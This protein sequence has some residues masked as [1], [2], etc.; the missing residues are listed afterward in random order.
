MGLGIAIAQIEALMPDAINLL[1]NP[2]E[3][4]LDKFQPLNCNIGAE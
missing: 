3:A 1:N 4:T 2:K